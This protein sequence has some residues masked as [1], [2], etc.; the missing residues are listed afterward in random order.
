[1]WRQG[2]GAN[3]HFALC[4]GEIML[5][6]GQRHLAWAAYERTA[7]LA[8]PFWPD[9]V[10]QQRLI[11]HCR[12]RQK[13]IEATLPPQEVE[14]LRP[15]YETELAYGLRYQKEYQ[16]DE[17]ARLAAGRPVTD[18]ELNAD[19]VSSHPPIASPVG[20]E[21]QLAVNPEQWFLMRRWLYG[22]AFAA[23]GAG[24]GAFAAAVLYRR[25]ARPT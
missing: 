9:P 22:F 23:L 25:F 15:R 18:P 10:R 20:P 11:D 7:S 13:L 5:R 16:A 17:A 14:K 21:D 4:L 19:F 8:S 3:P 6:V 24:L 1:M 12:S 2:G